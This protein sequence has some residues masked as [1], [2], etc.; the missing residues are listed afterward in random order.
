VVSSPIQAQRT[1]VDSPRRLATAPDNGVSTHDALEQ[2]ILK[3]DST[4]VGDVDLG[5]SY[6]NLNRAYF[7]GQLKE[8][9]VV[10]EP[11]LREVGPMIGAE[12]ILKG[13]TDGH[14]ILL[15]PV[16]RLDSNGFT[17]TLSHEM[18]HVLLLQ[19]GQPNQGHG[20]IFQAEL[21]RL[22]VGGAFKG[23][24]STPEGRSELLTFIKQESRRLDDQRARL[25]ILEADL[26]RQQD[27][28]DADI[29]GFNVRMSAANANQKDWPTD[30]ERVGL[31]RREASL[32]SLSADQHRRAAEFN[33]AMSRYNES[34]RRYNLMIVYPDG[35]DGDRALLRTARIGGRH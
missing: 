20:P 25:D 3:R 11:S 28:L 19:S 22:L 9:P 30:E 13:L 4:K 32:R 27:G 12:F 10:W 29:E 15:N 23:I 34:V 24:V 8:V 18:V 2:E 17:S 21:K 6:D 14:I 26:H 5:H 7:G 1:S 16:L 35:L 33:S 31:E